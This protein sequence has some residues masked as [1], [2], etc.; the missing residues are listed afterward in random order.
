MV[1]GL[2]FFL[3]PNSFQGHGEDGA[4]PICQG[5]TWTGL[6]FVSKMSNFQIGFQ[7]TRVFFIV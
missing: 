4:N 3:S 7:S 6:Q 2:F 5:A 1:N